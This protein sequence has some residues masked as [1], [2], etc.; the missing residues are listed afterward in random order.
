[1]TGVGRIIFEDDEYVLADFSD[2]F[3]ADVR[4]VLKKEKRVAKIQAFIYSNEKTY[5]KLELASKQFFQ[6]IDYTVFADAAEY[7]NL[8]NELLRIKSPR[9]FAMKFL[10]LLSPQLAKLVVSDGAD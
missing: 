10:R 1:M 2:N 6:R 9:E 7:L 5:V 4:L 3:A 8:R